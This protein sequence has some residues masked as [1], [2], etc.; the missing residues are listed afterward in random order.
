MNEIT[1]ELRLIFNIRKNMSALDVD[2]TGLADYDRS[3]QHLVEDRFN[4]N[5]V[6]TLQ[7]SIEKIKSM[8]SQIE[9]SVISKSHTETDDNMIRMDLVDYNRL[10]GLLV[11]KLDLLVDSLSGKAIL[12]KPETEL[13]RLLFTKTK[14]S[15]CFMQIVHDTLSNASDLLSQ[16]QTAQIGPIDLR[17]LFDVRRFVCDFVRMTYA[18]LMKVPDN[19]ENR[20]ESLTQ[21]IKNEQK[22]FK[23]LSYGKCDFTLQVCLR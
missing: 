5:L 13:F 12:C 21:T 14:S 10:F 7:T 17:L 22:F 9:S 6:S 1:N 11:Q 15:Q 18:N 23:D 20:R 8:R 2:E 4:Q 19:P 16:W 3:A